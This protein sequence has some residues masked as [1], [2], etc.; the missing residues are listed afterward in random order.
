MAYDRDDDGIADANDQFPFDPECQT[1]RDEDGVCDNND[2]APTD[3]SIQYDSDQ[4]GV[5]D[6]QDAFPNDPDCQADSGGDGV[7]DNRDIA[8]NDPAVQSDTD[9]DGISDA[10]D[11]CPETSG[12]EAKDGC[13]NSAPRIIEIHGPTDAYTNETLRYRVD[14]QDPDGDQLSITW[15]N[16]QTGQSAVYEFTASGEKNVSVV[17]GDGIVNETQ[18]LRVSVAQK[19]IVT[20]VLDSLREVL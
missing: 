8:P 20:Q 14:A 1:D 2:V 12:I 10:N 17:V 13:P 7:C 15:S 18:S 19:T 16:N 6:N 11:D 5:K 9:G 4:D 3:P